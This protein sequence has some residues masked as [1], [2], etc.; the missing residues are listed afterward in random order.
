MVEQ[1]TEKSGLRRSHEG[2]VGIRKDNYAGLPE[3][4]I[5]FNFYYSNGTG[6]AVMAIPESLLK[7]AEENEDLDM[8][9]VPFPCKYVLE[10]GYRM[11][12]NHVIC[13]GKYDTTFDL[14][15]NEKR[16]EQ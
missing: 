8:Y 12:K 11:Y 14:Q 15:I 3:E 9:E 1:L 10:K 4:L 5:E 2:L 16:Y 7:E 6:H 13:E